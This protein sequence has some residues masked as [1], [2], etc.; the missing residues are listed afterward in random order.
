MRSPLRILHVRAWTLAAALVA[1][2]GCSGAGDRQSDAGGTVTADESVPHRPDAPEASGSAEAGG[3]PPVTEAA[4]A[5]EAGDTVQAPSGTVAPTGF[6]PPMARRPYRD[7]IPMAP[8]GTPKRSTILDGK[9]VERPVDDPEADSV[10]RGRRLVDPREDLELERGFESADAL[11]QAV[12]DRILWNEFDPLL[13][14]RISKTE[15]RDVFW[16]EFPTSRP[17]T[18]IHA[19]EA[20]SFHDADSRDGVTE[21]LSGFGG[22][23]LH[24][25]GLRFE[26]GF[27]P[28]TNFNL[29]RGAVIEAVDDRGEPVVLRAATTFAERNGRWRIF[30]YKG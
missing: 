15:F 2:A 5:P 1:A 24:L 9:N 3:A 16:P 25:T 10:Q 22:R 21:L 18:N 30:T 13:D 28:Y 6:I 26:I 29:Y 20:W 23:E 11:A 17:V 8:M 4:A 12:L 19:D 7:D 14:L 27:A